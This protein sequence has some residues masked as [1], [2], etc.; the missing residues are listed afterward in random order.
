MKQILQEI[1]ELA[2][3]LNEFDFPDVQ[4]RRNWLGNPPATMESIYKVEERLGIVLPADYIEF[5][6]L[7][8]GFHAAST[9]KPTFV[10]TDEIDYLKNVDEFLISVWAGYDELA[11]IAD[12]LAKSIV[13]GGLREEQYFLLIP[14]EKYETEWRYWF[15]ASWLPGK[16]QFKDL[17]G[18][19]ANT[20]SFLQLKAKEAGLIESDLT[21]DFSLRNQLFAQDWEKVFDSVSDLF[22][23]FKKLYYISDPSDMLMLLHLSASKLNRYNEMAQVIHK[24]YS[25]N[26]HYQ[27]MSWEYIAWEQIAQNKTPFSERT[28]IRHLENAPSLERLH[29]MIQFRYPHL[30]NNEKDKT[31]WLLTQLF[32][33]GKA[34]EY[35][36][37]YES[38][39]SGLFSDYHLKAAIIFAIWKENDNAKQALHTYFDMAFKTRP[40]APFLHAE[41][42][43]V[44]DIEFSNSILQ[45]FKQ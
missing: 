35:I 12:G 28:S 26:E 11:D 17:P 8:N 10:T 6:K 31:A 14:P 18:Y 39:R 22:L 2:I 44:M 43:E 37:L 38:N 33:C 32:K 20:L 36:Q 15:F 4:R 16:E 1:S 42:S 40:L 5:L 24:A 41:L 23:N 9:V 21:V 34:P 25:E 13:I 7:C 19:F 45:K 29:I 30:L 3:L 27:M